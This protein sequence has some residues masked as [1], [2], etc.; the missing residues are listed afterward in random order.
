MKETPSPNYTLMNTSIGGDPAVVIVNSSLLNFS[1]RENFPWHLRVGV[2]CK[3][4]TENGMPTADELEVLRELDKK[5]ESVIE[6]DGNA[7]FLARITA[8][9]ER[10]TLYRIN[11][12]E[13]ADKALQLMLSAPAQAR[14]WEYQMEHDLSWLLA[15]P[16]LDLLDLAPE[17]WAQ[18]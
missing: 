9:G 8:L 17:S 7:I 18:G 5:F 13:I 2:S 15:K 4:Q 16:E 1:L 3:Y 10:V 6:R 14:E 12:P 11:E